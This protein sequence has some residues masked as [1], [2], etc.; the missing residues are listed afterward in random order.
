[1]KIFF[2]KVVADMEKNYAICKTELIHIDRKMS[3]FFKDTLAYFRDVCH[4]LSEIVVKEWTNI[5]YAG[6]TA[7]ER[8]LYMEHLIHETMDNSAKY[9][10][11]DKMFQN[12]PSYYRRSAINFVLGQKQSYETR[13]MEWQ[14]EKEQVEA[15]GK[16]FTKKC[17]TFNTEPE[18]YP[19]LYYKHV[20]QDDG[21]TIRIKVRCHRSW[22]W[23]DVK[24]AS[25]DRK[26]LKRK[27]QQVKK[28]GCPTLSYK[29]H[30]FYLSFPLEYPYAKFRDEDI[31]DRVVLAVDLGVNH[32][33]VCSLVRADGTIAGRFFD[34]FYDERGRINHLMKRARKVRRNSGT[35]QELGKIWTK[36]GCIKNNYEKHLAR[37]IAD[38]AIQHQVYGVVFEYLNCSK[39][40]HG[41]AAE[42]IH[43]WAKRRI[44][45]LCKGML[46]RCGIRAF[47]INPRNTSKLAFDGSGEVR[48]DKK[49]YS[50]CTFSTGKRYANDLNASYNIGARYFIRTYQ[51]AIPAKEWSELVAKV[52]GLSTRTLGTLSTLRSLSVN[53]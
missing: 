46:F 11:F 16:K 39:K 37:W 49:N 50:L 27:E 26:Y 9:P 36:Q 44:F 22:E 40:K 17:P 41:S 19:S 52:P 31:K 7:Q 4:Y 34:S 43:H 18:V 21:D 47:Q 35:G 10:E 15:S 14:D 8:M 28:I 13:C 48:R 2:R 20:F 38:I 33:A 53:L 6:A 45:K 12:F 5:Q 29:Y 30:K 42:K 23:V 32:G 1:M 51:K 25:A 3:R 24:M